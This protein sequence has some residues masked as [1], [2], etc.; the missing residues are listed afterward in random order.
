MPR[1]RIEKLGNLQ[2]TNLFA[3]CEVILQQMFG[4][5]KRQ[6]AENLLIFYKLRTF[7]IF[8][9]FCTNCQCILRADGQNSR[10]T[11]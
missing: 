11:S 3:N 1:L 4:K 9:P 7:P 10:E 8:S 2:N 5:C 6:K